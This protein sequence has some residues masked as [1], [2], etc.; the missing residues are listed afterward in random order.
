MKLTKYTPAILCVLFL[1]CKGRSV[2]M[3]DV[4]GAWQAITNDSIYEEVIISDKDYY[5]YDE[6][7][8]DL[9]FT[10]KKENDSLKLFYQGSPH[11]TYKRRL[12]PISTNEFVLADSLY[13]IRFTRLRAQVDTGRLMTLRNWQRTRTYDEEYNSEYVWALRE[14]KY[15]WDSLK[16]TSH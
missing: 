16:N 3:Y 9:Y 13:E 15:W 8:G 14:R 7:A 2:T 5:L 4:R 1:C 12:I 10:Y 6:H 11:V